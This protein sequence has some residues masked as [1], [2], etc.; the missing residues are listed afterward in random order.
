MRNPHRLFCGAR[1][2]QLYTAV[3]HRIPLTLLGEIE[4]QF[5]QHLHTVL[6]QG[7]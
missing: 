4:V 2:R 1:C 3:S 7:C 5:L 6:L